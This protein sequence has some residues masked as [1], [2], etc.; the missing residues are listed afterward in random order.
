MKK[1]I[2][3]V[4]CFVL[5]LSLAACGGKEPVIGGDPASWG[6]GNQATEKETV[7]GGDPASWGPGNQATETGE[8]E[9]V[10]IPNPW[11]ECSS[12]EEAGKIAGFSFTAP[13]RVD[14]FSEKYI[15]AI[16]SDVAEVIFHNG[17]NDENQ[18]SFRKGVGS[19]DISGDYN[20]YSSVETQQIDGKDVTVKGSDGMI[21]TVTWTQGGYAYAISARMGMTEEQ[22][23]SWIQALV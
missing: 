11:Q 5:A 9:N 19:E 13:E 22:M 14:G 3:C 4:V 21:Y 1:F 10:R 7:I 20:Q 6:P 17:E 12:L 16:E 18:V 23:N 8:N 15:A 2:V